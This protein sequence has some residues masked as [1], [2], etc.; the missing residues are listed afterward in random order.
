MIK[1]SVVSNMNAIKKT[2]QQALQTGGITP[3][4]AGGEIHLELKFIWLLTLLLL[5]I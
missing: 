3:L 4:A 5:K 1:A 2:S